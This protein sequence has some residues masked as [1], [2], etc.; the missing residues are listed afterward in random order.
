MIVQDQI[1]NIPNRYPYFL[2]AVELLASQVGE[3]GLLRYYL[4]L[5]QPGTTWPEVFR[6]AFGMTVEEFYQLFEEHRAA[7][8]PELN[9][10]K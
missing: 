9:V 5:K 4:A 10:P 8:F 6:E 3:H 1:R 7:G 2:L